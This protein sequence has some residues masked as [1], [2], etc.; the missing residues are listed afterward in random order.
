MNSKKMTSKEF[1]LKIDIKAKSRVKHKNI[2]RVLHPTLGPP[3]MFINLAI[4]P[5]SSKINPKHLIMF[6]HQ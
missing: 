2:V 4:H 6:H 3:N 1:C 5:M